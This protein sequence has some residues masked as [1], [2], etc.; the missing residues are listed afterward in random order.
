M[1][2]FASVQGSLV[3]YPIH[4]FGSEEQKTRLPPQD[5]QGRDHRLLRS[6][7]AGFRLEPERHADRRDR[8]RRQLRP[9]RHEALDHQ[10]QPR[11]GRARLGEG[12][13]RRRRGPRL[14]RSDRHPRLR[15]SPHPPQGE[16]S[17]ERHERAHSR[18]RAREEGR[19]P[20]GRARHEGPPLD[21]HGGALRHRVGR[22]RRRHGVLRLRGR[23]REAPRS[24]RRQAD[25]VAPARAG[26]ARARC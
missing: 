15:G 24:V 6:H 3:M 8:R 14:P 12:R 21:A 18:G 1:R 5:G 7:R 16:P 2:S 22:H 26:Q 13:R 23:L 25:R 10:R 4:A 17:R 20:P 19:D 9:Q 11:A